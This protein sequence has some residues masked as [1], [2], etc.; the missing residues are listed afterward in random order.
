MHISAKTGANRRL[1]VFQS[2]MRINFFCVQQDT[3]LVNS[4]A[5]LQLQRWQGPMLRRIKISK[6]TEFA[7]VDFNFFCEKN[8]PGYEKKVTH[9]QNKLSS[10][11][12]K[13]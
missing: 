4:R 2:R 8:G 7:L 5:A 12:T 13:I 10:K 3:L 9:A 6:Q 1:I 11:L